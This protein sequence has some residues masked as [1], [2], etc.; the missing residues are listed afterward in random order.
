M[1]LSINTNSSAATAL[2]KFSDTNNNLNKI[3]N[4]I[5]TGK[6]VNSPKDDAATLAIA[7]ELLSTYAG[8]DAVRDGLS[9]ASATVDVALA[10]GEATADILVELK[11]LAVQASQEGLD[12]SSRDALNSAFNSLRE[13][14][15]T[16][17]DSASFAGSNL[18]AAGASDQNVLS[19]DSGA[20]IKV[21]AQDLSSGGLGLGGQT[22][23][24]AGNA[25][26]ALTALDAAITD[27]SG[28][29]ANLGSSANR[30]ETHNEYLGVQND[31]IA[32]GVGN[33]VDADLA[34]DSAALKSS[35]IKQALGAISLGIANSSPARIL[36]LF[37]G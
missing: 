5:S 4:H 18:I 7:Q 10:A 20:T 32:A 28:K 14:V 34:A 29:L 2:Q 13:Q 23:D 17:N 22:L 30:I 16:I 15:T 12:Q 31:T 37:D 35:E 9:R 27:A 6:K 3:Q 21:A 24:N 25:A 33:L 36:S 8:T 26:S 1:A 11:G 19:D